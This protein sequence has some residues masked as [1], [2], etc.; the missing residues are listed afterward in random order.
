MNNQQGKSH[1]TRI[2]SGG[3]C[4]S[5]TMFVMRAFG[6]CYVTVMPR[7]TDDSQHNTSI[8]LSRPMLCRIMS[9]SVM[10]RIKGE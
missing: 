8:T 3:Y 7:M 1:N 6:L 4:I 5:T 10:P 9:K 2:T